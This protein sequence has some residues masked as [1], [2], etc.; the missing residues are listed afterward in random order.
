MSVKCKDCNK[1]MIPLNE[2]NEFCLAEIW[3]RADPEQDWISLDDDFMK[4]L[5]KDRFCSEFE[6]KKS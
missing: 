3:N 6:D 5:N 2:G 1:L 4:Y